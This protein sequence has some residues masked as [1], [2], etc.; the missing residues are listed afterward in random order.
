[1]QIDQDENQLHAQEETK[2]AEKPRFETKRR[3]FRNDSTGH[4]RKHVTPV[5]FWA[6]SDQVIP[7]CQSSHF[8]NPFTVTGHRKSVS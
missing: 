5:T 1:M 8:L 2:D 3:H 6:D 7:R 4:E